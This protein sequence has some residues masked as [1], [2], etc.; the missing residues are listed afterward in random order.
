MGE[1]REGH[2]MEKKIP[3]GRGGE[4]WR[5]KSFDPKGGAKWRVGGPK[6]TTTTGGSIL[7]TSRENWGGGETRV[8]KGG[9][10]QREKEEGE[11]SMDERVTQGEGSVHLGSRDTDSALLSRPAKWWQMADPPASDRHSN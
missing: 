4:R 2:S 11:A 3:K 6:A 9:G 5:G 1:R 7:Q 8:T 10:A